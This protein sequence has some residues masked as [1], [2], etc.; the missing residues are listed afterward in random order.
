MDFTVPKELI[1]ALEAA[2][3][4]RWFD[5]PILRAVTGLA[6]VRDVYNELRR[7]P[8]VRT[9]VEGLA[10]HD[11]VREIMGENL[12]AQ[13]SD[14]H[15]ELHERAAAY[16]EKRLEKTTGD[17]SDRLSLERLYHRVRTDEEAGTELFQEMA[18]ELTRYRLVNRLRALLNDVNTYPLERENSMLW[19]EYYYARVAQ[20]E[21]HSS[22][23]EGIFQAISE[24]EHAES[25]LRAYALCDWGQLLSYYERL[26]Q[27]GGEEKATSIL[28]K[29]LSLVP[30]D[31]HLVRSLFHLA[32]VQGHQLR[33]KETAYFIEKARDYFEQ[34]RD[35][36]GL[37]DVYG[38]SAVYVEMKRRFAK[39]GLWKDFF[40]TQAQLVALASTS[41]ESEALRNRSL[42][43]SNWVWALTGRLCEGEGN[44]REGV[45]TARSLGD[46]I[47]LANVLRD[48]GLIL[49]YQEHHTEANKVFLES[50]A[51]TERIGATFLVGS[52]LGFWGAILTKQGKILEA[53]ERLTQSIQLKEQMKD[54]GIVEP[55]AWLGK[56]YEIRK[57]LGATLKL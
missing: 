50:Q 33:R 34:T 51:L 22:D 42:S 54:P 31:S 11:A 25:K 1:P 24:N 44:A 8:F 55:W 46:Q 40:T 38:V 37:P 15:Y 48:L 5:Q 9:R 30:L 53:M 49:G 17:E 52:I 41:P 45:V 14:R 4:V 10:L 56:L 39:M 19:K 18:E 47:S 28:E 23:A 3:I 6:D 16:F 43:D 27:A 26:G 29:S 57:D 12:R 2:A 7:F 13:D 32:R 20:L 36:S 21:A 35:A